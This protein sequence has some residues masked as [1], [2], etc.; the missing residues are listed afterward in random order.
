[1]NCRFSRAET[2]YSESQGHII[3]VHPS[4]V[5]VYCHYVIVIFVSYVIKCLGAISLVVV[6]N[7]EQ[8]SDYGQILLGRTLVPEIIRNL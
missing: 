5:D 4:I 8:M 2:W 1:M 7:S 3:Q 6:Q